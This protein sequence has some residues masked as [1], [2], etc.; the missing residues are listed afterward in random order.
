MGYR[1]TP[2]GLQPTLTKV[3]AITEAP[4]PMNVSELKAFLGLVNYYGKFLN[5]LATTVAPLYKLLQKS[6]RW[7]WGPEE[8]SVFEQIK[9]QLTSDSLL[10]HYN[11]NAVLI[12]SCDASPYG[13]E[14]VLSHCFSEGTER[15]VAFASRTLAPAERRY[16]HLDKEA[17]A[18]IFGLKHFHQYL[19]GR[20]FVIYSDHK[21]LMYWFS[22][23]KPTPTMPS[24]RVQRWALTLSCYDYEIIDI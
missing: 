23:T 10:A 1:I 18:I 24:A 20:H 12:L 8:S 11:P 15:P 3:K 22:V 2:D 6:T 9:K 5:N 19:A 7:S 21:P 14:A 4:A 17:L 13:V 16:A